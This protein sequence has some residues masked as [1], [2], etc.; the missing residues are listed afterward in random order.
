MRNPFESPDR[1]HFQAAEGW[2]EL[3]NHMEANEELELLTPQNRAHPSVSQLRLQIYAQAGKWDVCLQ[4]ANA[5]AKAIP[6]H[7]FETW[8]IPYKLACHCAQQGQLEECQAW[9]KRAMAVDMKAVQ[10]TAIDDPELKPLWDSMS[11]TLWKR[12]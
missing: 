11:G 3:G 12:E 2:L 7:E 4:I 8:T 6:D 5:I 10:K 1:H 9:F